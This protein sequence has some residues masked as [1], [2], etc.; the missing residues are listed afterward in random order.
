MC[1]ALVVATAAAGAGCAPVPESPRTAYAV[2]PPASGPVDGRSAE[3]SPSFLIAAAAPGMRS[4]SSAGS[5]LARGALDD[6]RLGLFAAGEFALATGQCTDCGVPPA[7]LWWFRDE[8]IGVPARAGADERPGASAWA[9]D[10]AAGRT[11][12]RAGPA[13]AG[14]EARP[15]AV[16]W[17]GAPQRL[18][19]ARLSEDAREVRVDGRSLA[20]ELTPPIPTNAAYADASTARFFAGRPLTIRGVEIRGAGGPRFIARTIFPGDER[21]DLAALREAPLRPNELL[22]TLLEAQTDLRQRL[23]YARTDPARWAGLPVVAFVLS[24]AQGDDDGSRAGHLAIATGVLGERGEWDD[25]LVTNFYPLLEGNA[26]G[27]IP[28][29]L[30]M[31]NY[32]YD[33]N[34]GQLYYRPGYM[35]VAVLS[36][37]R[38]ARAVQHALQQTLHELHCGEI[39][40]DRARRNSTAMTIDPLREL[41]WRIPAVGPTSRLAGVAAAPVAA[42]VRRSLRTAGSVYATFAAERTRLLPRVAFEVAGHDLLQLATLDPSADADLTPFERMLAEDIEGVLFVR[43]AQVPSSRRFGTYPEPSLWAYGAALMSDPGDYEAA[44]DAK[45]RDF[46]EALRGTCEGSLP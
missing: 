27:I 30:P 5:G 8:V 2:P 34:S 38:A 10:N 19:G 22:G 3:D 7:A 26:K 45:E 20:L 23:L 28:A 35:L 11:A 21:V 42:I 46:P 4:T 16:V 13:P 40:F 17:L 36:G 41:G 37:P 39:E 32:L 6:G 12:E 43:L 25:W 9:A 18:S 14:N 33:L 1:R 31:D 29:S 24:G 15:P 44:P